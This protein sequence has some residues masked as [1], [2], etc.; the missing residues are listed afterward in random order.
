[1]M[2]K[3]PSTHIHAVSARTGMW[4]TDQ[5]GNADE[6][7][8]RKLLDSHTKEQSEGKTLDCQTRRIINRQRS[9][10]KRTPERPPGM[11][12]DEI[13]NERGM[14]NIRDGT[15][16]VSGGKRKKWGILGAEKWFYIYAT[17]PSSTTIYSQQL[18]AAIRS[19]S[20]LGEVRQ[21]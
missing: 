20:R 6:V 9:P 3:S 14:R 18:T 13:S 4:T 17:H 1:M 7:N 8:A 16:I 12:P 11:I 21:G 15:N 2:R 10:S 5:A 19:S